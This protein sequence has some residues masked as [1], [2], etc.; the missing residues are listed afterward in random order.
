[1]TSVIPEASTATPNP[2][3]Q[4]ATADNRVSA[5]YNILVG[6]DEMRRRA[7]DNGTYTPAMKAF[8]DEVTRLVATSP[9][10]AATFDEVL[11]VIS[12]E[13]AKNTTQPCHVYPGL[14]TA[15]DGEDGN[16]V[17]EN[18]RHY[19]HGGDMHFVPGLEIPGDGDPEIWAAFTHVSGGTPWIGFMGFDL[20]PEQA[21]VKAQEMRQFA[22]EV[23]A[24]AD[25]VETAV[26]KATA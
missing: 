18:G 14:C 6:L 3:D 2:Q 23:D 7:Q 5:A 21:R 25:Q 19:D 12:R 8:M 20:T 4:R 24:L 11:N 15:V 16:E 10:P 1:M 17:D 22:D 13:R 9:D 26:A